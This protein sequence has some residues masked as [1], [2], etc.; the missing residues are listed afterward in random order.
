MTRMHLGRHVVVMHMLLGVTWRR[1]K[2]GFM[3]VLVSLKVTG[4][5]RRRLPLQGQDCE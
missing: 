3:N 2:S 4:H 1:F 5:G